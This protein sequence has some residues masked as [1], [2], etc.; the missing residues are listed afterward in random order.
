[1]TA[2][3]PPGRYGSLDVDEQNVV[4]GFL[5]KPRGD[6]AWINGGFFMLGSEVFD[7]IDGDATLWEAEPMMRLARDGRLAAFRH[8]GFWAAMD[9]VRDKARLEELWASG[10]APWKVW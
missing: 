3:Q 8:N 2:V 1:V 7:Y 5:E 10:E 9:T 4:A 6:G